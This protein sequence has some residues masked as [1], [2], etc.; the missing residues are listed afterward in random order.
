MNKTITIG[1]IIATIAAVSAV[2]MLTPMSLVPQQ[3]DAVSCNVHD[4]PGP[5]FSTK[6]S[7]DNGKGSQQFHEHFG[8]C[9]SR[10]NC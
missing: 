10:I 2:G 6:C 7:Q 3:A 5:D 9:K 4:P 8:G 1:A